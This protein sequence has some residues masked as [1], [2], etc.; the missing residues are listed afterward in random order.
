M[1]ALIAGI[2]LWSFAHLM[3]SVLPGPRAVLQTRL[4]VGPHKGL[5]ALTLALALALIIYGWRH[6]V[7]EYVY[8]PPVWGRHLNFLTM[9]FAIILFGASQ[10]KSRLR[11][12]VRHPMLTGVLVWALGHLA[13]NGDTRSL[14]LFGGMGLW[15]LV[16]IFTISAK[17]GHWV[18]PAEVA[19]IGRELLGILIALVLYGILFASH[20]WFA[21]V[22]L[23]G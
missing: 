1:G 10:G 16:S 11:Q 13:A 12:W 7:P 23:V 3:P 22:A 4:G 15:A 8:D 14:I 6:M 5:V 18:K 21:G 17:E 19:S 2:I 9:F 20:Q